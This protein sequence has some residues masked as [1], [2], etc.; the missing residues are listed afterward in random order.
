M[1][2]LEGVNVIKR[3]LGSNKVHKNKKLKHF[4]KK[5]VVSANLI[6]QKKNA[7]CCKFLIQFDR[8]EDKVLLTNTKG[9]LKVTLLLRCWDLPRICF[10]EFSLGIIWLQKKRLPDNFGPDTSNGLYFRCSTN[11]IKIKNSVLLWFL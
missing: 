2:C 3:Y 1:L 10:S 8:A 7:F 6:R 11:R 4:F 9:D 5:L